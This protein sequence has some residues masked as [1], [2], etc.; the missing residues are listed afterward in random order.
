MIRYY[1][2]FLILVRLQLSPML[3]ADD[4]RSVESLDLPGLDI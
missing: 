2:D 3:S 4:S 1:T